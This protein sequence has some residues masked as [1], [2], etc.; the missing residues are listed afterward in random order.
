MKPSR[1]FWDPPKEKAFLCPPFLSSY[2]FI[3]SFCLLRATP[4]AYGDSQARG[5]I[6]VTAASLYHCHSN[7]GSKQPL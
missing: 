5:P 4:A 6:A 2:L 3:L 1:T 7:A